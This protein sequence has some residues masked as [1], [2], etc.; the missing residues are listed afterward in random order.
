MVL[1]KQLQIKN[2]WLLSTCEKC[3]INCWNVT[4]KSISIFFYKYTYILHFT[5]KTFT[6]Y[7]IQHS[8]NVSTRQLL[9]VWLLQC[10]K[11]ILPSLWYNY[12]LAW[13]KYSMRKSLWCL[14]GR[15][16]ASTGSTAFRGPN[17][18]V[19]ILT[20]LLKPIHIHCMEATRFLLKGPIS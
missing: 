19:H 6:I 9:L 7:V 11:G 4:D 1:I 3:S 8:S 17:K 10:G 2:I 13:S 12:I 15:H 20:H 5:F 18:K 16:Q 14:Q